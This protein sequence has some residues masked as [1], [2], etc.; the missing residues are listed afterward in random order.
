MP[1]FPLIPI[2]A[3]GVAGALATDTI[4]KAGDNKKIKK[5]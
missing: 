3:T 5:Y 2:L 1:A 4:R